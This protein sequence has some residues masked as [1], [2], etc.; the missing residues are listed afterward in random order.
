MFFGPPR[1]LTTTATLIV[2][3]VD[4]NDE[5]PRFNDSNYF[6]TVAENAPGGTEVGRL[7]AFDADSTSNS[8][9]TF[10]LDLTPQLRDLFRV[11]LVTGVIYTRRALDREVADSYRLKAVVTGIHA[12]HF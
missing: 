4:V 12:G 6:M 8:R 2:N 5:G 10:Q 11:D 9:H 1:R 7:V 3:V